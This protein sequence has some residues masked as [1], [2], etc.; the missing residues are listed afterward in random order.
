VT[1]LSATRDDTA[2]QDAHCGGKSTSGRCHQHVQHDIPLDAPIRASGKNRTPTRTVGGA[3]AAAPGDDVARAR[4]HATRLTTAGCSSPSRVGLSRTPPTTG[5][6]TRPVPS[7]CHPPS[8]APRLRSAR[9]TCGTR[10]CPRGCVRARTRPRSPAGRQQRRGSS[11]PVRE[12][13]V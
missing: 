8:P 10:R 4:R 11:E 5:P 9:T 7:P 3:A 13:P 1:I 6:G 12:V 2:D